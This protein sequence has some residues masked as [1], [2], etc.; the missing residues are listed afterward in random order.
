[1]YTSIG[2]LQAGVSLTPERMVTQL[3]YCPPHPPAL[4]DLALE[5]VSFSS[6]GLSRGPATV[7][8]LGVPPP[9][10][11]ASRPPIV[12]ARSLSAL[13]TTWCARRA[14]CGTASCTADRAPDYG[15]CV[16]RAA[17]RSPAVAARLTT[18]YNKLMCGHQCMLEAVQARSEDSKKLNTSYIER[19]NL[20]LRR[21][22]SYLHRPPHAAPR[23]T[24]VNARCTARPVANIVPS[25]GGAACDRPLHR[26]LG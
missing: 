10:A 5:I 14:S 1:M 3:W 15:C 18:G 6:G 16:G 25:P 2:M 26:P 23:S 21:R 20:F 19:L 11:S 7:A 24:T 4:H 12:A 17:E 22:C 9:C 8:P 13:R